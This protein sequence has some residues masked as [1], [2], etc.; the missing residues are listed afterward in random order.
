[1]LKTKLRK[2]TK[3]I[4]DEKQMNETRKDEGKKA[5]CPRFVLFFRD[6]LVFDMDGR[7]F[8]CLSYHETSVLH[9]TFN[10]FL[11]SSSD[12]SFSD[13]H[14]PKTRKSLSLFSRRCM[15][16]DMSLVP[17]PPCVYFHFDI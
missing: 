15:Y 3:S 5:I 16:N 2:I 13:R 7:T 17:S 10:P 9:F 14:P 12:F 8:S 6:F 1:M 11:W 4:G